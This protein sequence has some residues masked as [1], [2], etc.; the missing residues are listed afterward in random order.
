MLARISQ[1]LCTARMPWLSYA[2]AISSGY[3]CVRV[4]GY[5]CAYACVYRCVYRRVCMCVHCV[6]RVCV[7]VHVCALCVE[8]V[9]VCVSVDSSPQLLMHVAWRLVMRENPYVVSAAG[10][11]PEHTQIPHK[12]TNLNLLASIH[13]R[14]KRCQPAHSSLASN[15]SMATTPVSEAYMLV[16]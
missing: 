12:H 16:C 8:S 1:P 14:P 6:W 5:L 11:I 13:T 15:I 10:P 9:C 7:C 4:G 2:T 3:G